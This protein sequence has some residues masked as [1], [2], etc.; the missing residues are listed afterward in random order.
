MKIAIQA[1]FAA[2]R[3]MDVYTAHPTK[4]GVEMGI[5]VMTV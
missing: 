4:V 3:D 2:K 5:F 1:G